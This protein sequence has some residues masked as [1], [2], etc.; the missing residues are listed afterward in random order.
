MIH[1]VIIENVREYFSEKRMRQCELTRSEIKQYIIKILELFNDNY[2]KKMHR[3]DVS[4][5]L[6]YRNGDKLFPL[7]VGGDKADRNRQ[8]EKVSESYVYQSLNMPGKMK[9][10][11]YVK[12]IERPDRY[13]KNILRPNIERVQERATGKY[14][15][16]IAIPIRAGKLVNFSTEFD[17]QTDLGMIG[18]DLQEKFGFGNFEEQELHLI[19]CFADLISEIVQDLINA[20]RD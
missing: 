9:P 1:K 14:N 5:V 11:I 13:E 17:T 12:D 8:A 2:M 6:K 15:T 10:Y 3:P 7:R 18:F 20:K 4:A 16:F 19:A